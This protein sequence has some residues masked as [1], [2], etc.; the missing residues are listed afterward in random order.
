MTVTLVLLGGK[1]RPLEDEDEEDPELVVDA[2]LVRKPKSRKRGGEETV[3]K[4]S[5][6]SELISVAY[7]RWCLLGYFSGTTRWRAL[8]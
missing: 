3:S 5:F 7:F 8:C 1:K 4:I 2:E 6:Q